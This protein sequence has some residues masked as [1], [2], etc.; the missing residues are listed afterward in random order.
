MKRHCWLIALSVRTTRSFAVCC[1]T[2]PASGTLLCAAREARRHRTRASRNDAYHRP[3][4]SEAARD[5]KGGRRGLE[6]C[7]LETGGPGRD[8]PRRPRPL[9]RHASAACADG[10]GAAGGAVHS[11]RE[12]TEIRADTGRR[13]ATRSHDGKNALKVPTRAAEPLFNLRAQGASDAAFRIGM[14]NSATR[15][16]SSSADSGVVSSRALRANAL[17]WASRPG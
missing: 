13:P 8:R 11:V 14:A 10:P 17:I 16:P 4:A 1:Q 3:G 6:R 15:C 12:G 9:L 5:A 2:D 7:R